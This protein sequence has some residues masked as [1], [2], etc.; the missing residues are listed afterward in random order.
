MTRTVKAYVCACLV[1]QQVKYNIQPLVGL[2]Q[3]FPIPTYI[4]QDIDMDFITDL[5]LSYGYLVIFVIV[6]CLS[7][8]AYFIPL[9]A[10]F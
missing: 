5:P 6:D 2:L 7:K 10:D 1:C 4:W 9:P 8:F 3:S